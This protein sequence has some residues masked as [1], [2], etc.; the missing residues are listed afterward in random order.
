VI[1]FFP[2]V[3]LLTVTIGL[4]GTGGAGGGVGAFGFFGT[5]GAFGFFG[6]FG[7]FGF[8]GSFV[9]GAFGFFGTFGVFAFGAFVLGAFV[10]FLPPPNMRPN[11]PGPPPYLT[12]PPP[13]N[14]GVPVMLTLLGN[15]TAEVLAGALELLVFPTGA[16]DV[17]FTG[18]FVFIARELLFPPVLLAELFIALPLLPLLLYAELPMLFMELPDVAVLLYALFPLE[19][20][21]FEN[22]DVTVFF[23]RGLTSITGS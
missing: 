13:K 6:T 7:A 15:A 19:T 11:I 10:F 1:N 5:F 20:V 3:R 4:P 9:F 2:L 8:F 22:S 21:L 23:V 16:L 18:A 14:L 12:P 17:E